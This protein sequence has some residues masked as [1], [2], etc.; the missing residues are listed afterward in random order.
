MKS[1]KSPLRGCRKWEEE[2]RKMTRRHNSM[3]LKKTKLHKAQI[4]GLRGQKQ[5]NR[6]VNSLGEE[7]YN[8]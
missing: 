7:L 2:I 1:V 8:F 3:F 6:Y 4:I 5:K